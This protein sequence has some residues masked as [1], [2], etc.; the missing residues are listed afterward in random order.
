MGNNIINGWDMNKTEEGFACL[1]NT[2]NLLQQKPVPGGR[3][4]HFVAEV[5]SAVTHIHANGIIHLDIKSQN[6][7]R[8]S[9]KRPGDA[10]MPWCRLKPGACP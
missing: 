4:L 2:E 10:V 5:L 1:A 6:I 3:C 8:Q 7:M 9:Q